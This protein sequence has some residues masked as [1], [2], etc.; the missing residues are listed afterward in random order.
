M[1]MEQMATIGLYIAKSIFRVHGI[2]E[3]QSFVIA[4]ANDRYA[5]RSEPSAA[6]MTMMF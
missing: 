5:L 6:L 3:K 1:D 4:A 2:G